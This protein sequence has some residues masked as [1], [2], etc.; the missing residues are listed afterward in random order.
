MELSRPIR[1]VRTEAGQSRRASWLELF[2]DL[3]FVAAVAQV[4]VPLRLD[5][6][7]HGLARYALMFLLIWWA[8]LG[9]T[10]YSS[11]FDSDDLLHRLLTFMQMFAAAAMAANAKAA[12]ES[13][14]S[15]GFGAAYATLRTVQS[16][17]YFRARRL[18]DTRRLTTL[19]AF[20][21]GFAAVT[22]AVA[23]LVPIPTRFYL[24]T[25]ALI[26]DL[27][28]PWVA[29]RYTHKFPPH[30]EHLP[31][32][33]GL[34]TIILLGES[35]AAVMRG[36]ESQEGWPVTAAISAISGLGL[37]FGYWWWY[38]DGVKGAAERRIKSRR[39]LGS[40]HLWTYVHF[41]LYLSIAIVGVGVEHVISLPPGSHLHREESLILV[42]SAVSVMLL[43]Q[44]VGLTSDA[45]RKNLSLSRVSVLVYVAALP[46]VWFSAVLPGWVLLLGL[47][48]TCGVG[49][50]LTSSN[51]HADRI[52]SSS[53]AGAESQDLL[54][55]L[56]N[57]PQTKSLQ[58]YQ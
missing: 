49:V 50:M 44:L 35:V 8:W 48:T 37:A 33:F 30:P 56:S 16:I 57:G 21:F 40:F 15:A 3:L 4:S 28:T 47:S 1:L 41:P 9:H 14:D 27:S 45:E 58:Q 24:W 12:F 32:R 39:N 2:F 7:L 55:Q 26:V 31:E 52:E 17:Q 19:C 22:W 42:L 34:F 11:R 13:R 53:T 23:A 51:W 25:V 29:A 5:Y 10:M 43:L 54:H 36:M 18:R 6:T 38:F 46:V 20:G